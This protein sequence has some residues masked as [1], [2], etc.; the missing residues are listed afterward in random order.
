M[1]SVGAWTLDVNTHAL[2]WSKQIYDIVEADFTHQPTLEEAIALY[3][4]ESAAKL[5]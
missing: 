1:C 3:P 5:S 2:S 4:E